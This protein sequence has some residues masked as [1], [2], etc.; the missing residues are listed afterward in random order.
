MAIR[1]LLQVELWSKGTTRK[2]LAGLAVVVVGFGVVFTAE[3]RWLSPG[4]RVAAKAALVELDK[5]QNPDS[6]MRGEFLKETK[7]REMIDAADHAAWTLRDD[8]LVQ[9]LK[10]YADWLEFRESEAQIRS[11]EE[12][13]QG[14]ITDLDRKQ[15]GENILLDRKV[16]AY[17]SG[18]LHNVLD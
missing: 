13:L 9:G 1:E 15:D 5:L 11:S 6:E 4:E 8:R 2:I 18:A 3:V 12:Q 16:G 7:A 14:G 17:V 10:S